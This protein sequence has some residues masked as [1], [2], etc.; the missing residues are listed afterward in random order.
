MPSTFSLE[1]CPP[2][3]TPHRDWFSVDVL[4]LGPDLVLLMFSFDKFR[5]SL[6]NMDCLVCSALCG[7]IST[8][9]K[10]EFTSFLA[11]FPVHIILE[12][13][14]DGTPCFTPAQVLCLRSLEN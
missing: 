12:S 6:R 8:R 14:E 4:L 5:A 9:Q 1:C 13:D 10:N 7:W 3:D 11:S 2:L